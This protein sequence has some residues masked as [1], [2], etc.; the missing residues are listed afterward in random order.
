MCDPGG[1][2]MLKQ[3]GDER[4]GRLKALNSASAAPKLSMVAIDTGFTSAPSLRTPCT[5][6]HCFA[7]IYAKP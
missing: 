3:A 5:L 2:V 4:R 1:S 7:P 6:L